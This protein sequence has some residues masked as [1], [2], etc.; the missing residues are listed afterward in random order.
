MKCERGDCAGDTPRFSSLET[1]ETRSTAILQLLKDK[2]LAREQELARYL[3]QAGNASNVR[4]RAARVRIDH[5]VSSAVKAAERDA[6]QQH[7]K[8][9][10]PKQELSKP[11][12]K[13]QESPPNTGGQTARESRGE[14]EVRNTQ[15]AAPSPK[16]DDTRP[17]KNQNQPPKENED[18]E[19]GESERK[20]AA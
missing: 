9:Q 15:N 7:T 17:E 11:E 10:A 12:E 16:S 1:L 19:T 20:N 8:Q 6:K 13:S 14:K 18:K 2:G 3:E 4:W 5:L